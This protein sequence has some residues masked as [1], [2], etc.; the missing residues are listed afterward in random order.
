[1]TTH[2]GIKNI[3]LQ[4]NITIATANINGW[5]TV[6]GEHKKGSKLPTQTNKIMRWEYLT[7]IMRET[8][9][10][11]LGVQEHHYKTFTEIKNGTHRFKRNK[12]ESI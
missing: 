5:E 2:G 4:K 3:K 8:K 9:I 12:Y 7:K 11:I 1:M 10:D 6:T